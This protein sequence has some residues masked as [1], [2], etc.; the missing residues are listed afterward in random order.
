MPLLGLALLPECG[1]LLECLLHTAIHVWAKLRSSVQVPLSVLGM[2]TTFNKKPP[3]TSR[4]ISTISKAA[5]ITYACVEFRASAGK[6]CC[7]SHRMLVLCLMLSAVQGA[8]S[9]VACNAQS[10]IQLRG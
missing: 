1:Q 2:T 8:K 6:M 9:T 4:V 7:S 10:C 3:S 5:C